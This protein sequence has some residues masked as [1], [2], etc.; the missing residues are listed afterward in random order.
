M[1]KKMY[2]IRS[3]TKRETVLIRKLLSLLGETKESCIV[4]SKKELVAIHEDYEKF[5]MKFMQNV[6]VMKDEQNIQYFQL[7]EHIRFE[8]DNK[9]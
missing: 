6:I 8:K 9:M 1:K 4:I 5:L 2:S 3:Y 7:I